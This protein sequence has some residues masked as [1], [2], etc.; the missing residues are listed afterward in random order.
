M[1][2]SFRGGLSTSS[3]TRVLIKRERGEAN[4]R[5]RRLKVLDYK[6]EEKKKNG[7]NNILKHKKDFAKLY[8]TR[9]YASP[10]RRNFDRWG[11]RTFKRETP[12]RKKVD[13]NNIL[14][15]SEK[16]TF[17]KCRKNKYG[18]EL[19]KTKE[20]PREKKEGQAPKNLSQKKVKNPNPQEK[21]PYRVWGRKI[22]KRI[23]NQ[24]DKG[25]YREG[26]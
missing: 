22:L 19:T 11:I 16:M 23:L 26:G 5:K 13:G 9:P 4:G 15:R 3:E 18:G 25:S 1:R 12:T 24:Q 20:N 21:Q 10:Q 2:E 8:S 6:E 7:K 17:F 14:Q